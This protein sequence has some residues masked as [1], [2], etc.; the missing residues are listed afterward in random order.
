MVPSTE[1]AAAAMVARSPSGTVPSEA[2]VI[3]TTA[4][5]PTRTTMIPP[6]V[7]MISP[8]SRTRPATPA[9]T[10]PSLACGFSDWASREGGRGS[11][12]SLLLPR[13]A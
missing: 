8:T 7:A 13:L 6:E 3:V 11:R 1:K 4:P 2:L 10:P 9:R 5:T 12:P